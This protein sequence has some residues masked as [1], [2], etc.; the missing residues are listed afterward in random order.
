MS[1]AQ[2]NTKKVLKIAGKIS[3]PLCTS[4]PVC[5]TFVSC[6]FMF[7]N[8]I[9]VMNSILNWNVL[10][11][12]LYQENKTQSYFILKRQCSPYYKLIA[13]Q[14]QPE[15]SPLMLNIESHVKLHLPQYTELTVSWLNSCQTP[16]KTDEIS[17]KCT[18]C[19]RE[20]KSFLTGFW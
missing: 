3:Q 2:L 19:C 14:K 11:R 18:H 13:Y 10:V 17:T 9:L 16:Q 12:N 7:L 6:V 5:V 8:R 1:L 15:C 20:Y 4:S